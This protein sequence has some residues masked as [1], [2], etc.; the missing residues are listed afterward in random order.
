MERRF[1]PKPLWP[2]LH[3]AGVSLLV[4][5]CTNSADAANSGT[6]VGWGYPND[7]LGLP[8]WPTNVVQVGP[9]YSHCLALKADGTVLAWGS[10]LYGEATAPTGLSNVI[11]VA[12]GPYHNLAL[13][14]NG[15]VIQW[16]SANVAPVPGALS[17]VVA[18]A[19]GYN[20]SLA[21]KNTGEVVAWG[22]NYNFW[23]QASV[24]SS[25]TDAV[26]IAA[27]QYFAMA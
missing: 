10:G 22:E 7:S 4:L 26:A 16:G 23:G 15:T 13:L 1:L 19:A 14:A 5:S 2:W 17:N 11:V 20:L 6:V 9:A 18:V 3:A 21:L 24:P 12:A 27:G 8:A 25:L